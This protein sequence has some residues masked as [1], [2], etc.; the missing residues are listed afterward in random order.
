MSTLGNEE[1]KNGMLQNIEGLSQI[2]NEVV[3]KVTVN[4]QEMETSPL[5]NLNYGDEDG[6]ISVDN[7]VDFI[8]GRAEVTDEFYGSYSATVE[9]GHLYIEPKNVGSKG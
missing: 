9:D 7:V 6:N 1:V 5:S 8:S 4:G 3:H 2:A